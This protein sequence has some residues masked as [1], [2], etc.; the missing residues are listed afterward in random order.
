MLNYLMSIVIYSMIMRASI[1]VCKVLLKNKNRL[2]KIFKHNEEKSGVGV[3]I[4]L[5]SCIPI[6]RVFVI[7]CMYYLCFCNDEQFNEIIK[8]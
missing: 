2:D 7:I 3:S 6:F 5:T 4:I 1:E 8:D